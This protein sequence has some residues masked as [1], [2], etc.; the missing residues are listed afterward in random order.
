MSED[1]SIKDKIIAS[2]LKNVNF[3]GWSEKSILSGFEA[4]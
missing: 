4:C 3:D 2:A 1:I